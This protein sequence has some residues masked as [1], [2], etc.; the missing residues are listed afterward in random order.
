MTFNVTDE[1]DI[2]WMKSRLCD[3]PTRTVTQPVQFSADSYSKIAKTCIR[4]T[5][6]SLFVEAG[7]RAK[8]QGFQYRELLSAGHDAMITKPKELVGLFLEVA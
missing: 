5:P 2:A 8:R 7:E 6:T 4:C 1:H 3:H